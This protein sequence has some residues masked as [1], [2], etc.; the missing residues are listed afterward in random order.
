MTL[1]VV[2]NAPLACLDVQKLK[3]AEWINKHKSSISTLLSMI[4]VGL[5]I[6]SKNYL[7]LPNLNLSEAAVLG[8]NV[9]IEGI[10]KNINDGTFLKVLV[11]KF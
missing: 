4:T 1:K 6:I 11:E 10:C 3:L 2:C 9:S 5:T 8:E 7:T